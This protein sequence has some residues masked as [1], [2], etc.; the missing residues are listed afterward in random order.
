MGAAGLAANETRSKKRKWKKAPPWYVE[1]RRAQYL[2]TG[3][4][5]FGE[6]VYY[7]KIQITGLRGRVFGPYVNASDAISAFDTILRGALEAFC[8]AQNESPGSVG[9]EHIAFPEDL[10][11]AHQVRQ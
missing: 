8:E 2:F 4:D 5:E 3:T 1:D 7:F 10:K 6:I 9:V 11:P